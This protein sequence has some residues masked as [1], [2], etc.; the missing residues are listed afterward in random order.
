MAKEIAQMLF[1]KGYFEA[2]A[3]F[4]SFK[5]EK[6]IKKDHGPAW[7]AGYNKYRTEALD[8]IIEEEN[9][10]W[11]AERA[12]ERYFEEGP[13]HRLGYIDPRD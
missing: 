10:E 12:A 13:S 8:H 2:E 7:C 5:S 3:D 11:E 9:A 1:M 6:E 4:P